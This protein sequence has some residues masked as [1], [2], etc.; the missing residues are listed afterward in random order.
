MSFWTT[1]W[2]YFTGSVLLLLGLGRA[3][4]PGTTKPSFVERSLALGLVLFAAPMGVFGT[5]H[6]VFPSVIAG[7]VPAWLPVH[8]FWTY[9]TGTALIAA[10]LSIVV[11]RYSGLAAALLG[12]MLLCF[13]VMISV[14]NIAR[15]PGDRF[16]LAVLLRDLSFAGAAL[17][18]AVVLEFPPLFRNSRSAIRILR[19]S[20]AVP[21]IVF[22]LEHFLHPGFVPAVP[23][24]HPLP[25]WVPA[26]VAFAYVVGTILIACGSCIALDWRGAE[27][28]AILGWAVVILV[29]VVYVPLL[30]SEPSV[31]VGLNY[32]M[33]TLAFAGGALIWAGALGRSFEPSAAHSA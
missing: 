29:L 3:L 6:F 5:E 9:L 30:V 22:G 12:L 19:P 15:N 10:A 18:L 27:A 25:A 11:N 2:P 14:P 23:L 32:F 31:A 17:A 33:D 28:A 21:S 7:M 16:V 1:F 13:V 24:E 8:L 26:P 20:I 4:R